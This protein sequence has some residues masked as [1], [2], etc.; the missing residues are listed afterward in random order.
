MTWGRWRRSLVCALMRQ[1]DQ[2]DENE[3]NTESVEQMK[4]SNN[5]TLRQLG[6]VTVRGLRDSPRISDMELR[7][8]EELFTKLREL[9]AA[10]KRPAEFIAMVFCS[11]DEVWVERCQSI[12]KN[13]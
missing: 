3:T 5:R 8:K 11:E 13:V 9:T 2:R 4:T 12:I 1:F 10:L 7:S 6:W